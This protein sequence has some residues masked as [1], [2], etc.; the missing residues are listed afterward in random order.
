MDLKHAFTNAKQYCST[1]LKYKHKLA[2][3][4][5]ILLGALISYRLPSVKFGL[6]FGHWQAAISSTAAHISYCTAYCSADKKNLLH[7]TT[8]IILCKV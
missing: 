2:C 8:K 6:Q 3:H 1:G 4:F 5:I 7:F